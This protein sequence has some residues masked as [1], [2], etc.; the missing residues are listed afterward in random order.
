MADN[1]KDAARARA[2]LRFKKQEEAATVRQK[3][4][5]EYTAESDARKVK[6][7]KLRALR[8]AK[9]AEELANAPAAPAKKPAR[10]KK[11]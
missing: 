3:A 6:T 10:A 9:E 1:S 8:L 7:D 2:D 11:K 4:M 5:A